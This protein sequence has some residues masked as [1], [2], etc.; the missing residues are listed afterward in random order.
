M[1]GTGAY[2]AMLALNLLPEAPAHAFTLQSGSG[3]GKHVVV[4]ICGSGGPL[5]QTNPRPLG[6]YTKADACTY[7]SDIC[8]RRLPA[9]GAGRWQPPPVARHSAQRPTPDSRPLDPLT[10]RRRSAGAVAHAAQNY[11]LTRLEMVAVR[12]GGPHRHPPTRTSPAR[13]WKSRLTIGCPPA[14][15]PHPPAK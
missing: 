13:C 3:Q 11:A 9:G 10:C 14:R 7:G 2:S 6:E 5:A 4:L 15:A 12:A 8:C 1:L